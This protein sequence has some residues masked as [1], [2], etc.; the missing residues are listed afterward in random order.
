MKRRIN[1]DSE[2]T[3]QTR[4]DAAESTDARAHTRRRSITTGPLASEDFPALR[5]QSD[6]HP[7]LYAS[8]NQAPRVS[9]MNPPPAPNRQLPSPPGRTLSSP[10]SS[11]NFSSPSASQYSGTPQGVNLPLPSNSHQPAASS[12]LP[13]ITTAR[14]PDSALREHSAALQ[15]EVSIQKLA[16]SSLQS[17]HDKLL[18]AFSR[19]QL[20]ATTLEKK[21]AVSDSEIISLS[22]EKLRLQTQVIELER[23]VEELSRSRDECRQAAVLEGAQ[24]VE[25]VKKASRLEEM[26]GEEKKQWSKLKE[27]MERRID[28]LTTSRSRRNVNTESISTAESSFLRRIFDEGDTDTPTSST[29]LSPE[30][31]NEPMTDVQTFAPTSQSSNTQQESAADLKEE[32]RRLRER[33]LEVENALQAIRDDGRSMDGLVK[34][35]LAR[36]EST[37]RE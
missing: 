16:L 21:H 32:I 18:A 30:L 26:A 6:Y 31:K 13:P 23:D 10:T 15:H 29:D 9:I 36:A 28:A 4:M 17:E 33:C 7:S 14:S 20:R 1:V 34:S 22:E 8:D 37:L 35:L 11:L 12:Y 3:Q 19:S 5:Q 2:D 24:Y 27:D 25:I